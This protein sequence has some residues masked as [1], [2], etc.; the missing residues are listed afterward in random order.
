MAT[1]PAV[2]TIGEE[3]GELV[4]ILLV[5]PGWLTGT[6]LNGASSPM[7]QAS[8]L[9]QA[10]SPASDLPRRSGWIT[11]RG[12]GG[13]KYRA[14]T[15]DQGRFAIAGV[16][17]GSYV[18]TAVADRA[19]AEAESP[20]IAT[21]TTVRYD[22]TEESPAVVHVA[23]VPDATTTAVI[24][25]DSPARIW[26]EV[27]I[28]GLPSQGGQVLLF[29][30]SPDSP[31][32][33]VV[34]KTVTNGTGIYEF[35]DVP[36][37]DYVVAVRPTDIDMPRVAG[38][39]VVA[40]SDVRADMYFTGQSITGSVIDTETRTGVEGAQVWITTESGLSSAMEAM[41]HRAEQADEAFRRSVRSKSDGEILIRSVEPGKYRL[42]ATRAGYLPGD[43]SLL[44]VD[45]HRDPEAVTLSLSLA[46]ELRGTVDH[47]FTHAPLAGAEV[48]ISSLSHDVSLVTTKTDAGG[49]FAVPTLLAGEY[50]IEVVDPLNSGKVVAS[51]TVTLVAGETKLVALRVSQ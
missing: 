26:G 4:K 51:M 13:Q 49:G 7:A 29:A 47:E 9:A 36:R 23:V 41:Y 18:L 30:S 46:A 39:Q 45:E 27:L 40:G 6:V 3:A 8:V 42:R 5:R 44:E 24:A 48:R 28:G 12:C 35:T 32:G 19:L 22:T 2:A 17:P 20:E 14:L 10:A 37:G 11:S 33:D 31:V 15:D 1:A 16:V 34:R 21:Y 38:L 50:R 25:V 43:S